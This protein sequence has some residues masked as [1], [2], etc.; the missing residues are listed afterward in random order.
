MKTSIIPALVAVGW[1]GLLA[2]T[3][4]VAQYGPVSPVPQNAA[5]TQAVPGTPAMDANAQASNRE[6]ATA[7]GTT[8]QVPTNDWLA[9]DNGLWD[10]AAVGPCCSK[11]GGGSGCPPDWYTM[12]GVRIMSRSSPRKGPISF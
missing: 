11:C 1:I 2:N 10:G 4:A 7:P 9:V 12:Q 5:P 6:M 3:Q 8:L